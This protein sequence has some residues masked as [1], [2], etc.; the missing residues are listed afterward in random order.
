MLRTGIGRSARGFNAFVLQ[1]RY[2]SSQQGPVTI[3]TGPMANVAKKLKLFSITSLGLGVGISPF[4]FVIDVPVPF[5]AKAA[6]VGAGLIQWVMSPY[7]TK[8]TV[9]KQPEEGQVPKELT[10]HTLSFTARD[11]T[12][13]VP[14]DTIAPASRI[15]TTW[16]ITDPSQAVGRIGEKTAKPKSL[17]YIHPELCQ[18]EGVMKDIIEK[19]GIGQ[20]F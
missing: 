20:G 16:M 4:V 19:T 10:I 3:Y 15:F 13:T 5:V 8:I 18:E 11:H 2:T 7:V 14:V 1:K 12:T 17:L 9:P 6:L